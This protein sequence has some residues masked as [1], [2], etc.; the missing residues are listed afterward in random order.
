M[1]DPNTV[2]ELVEYTCNLLIIQYNNRPKAQATIK[3]F[4][5]A[6]LAN[7][8][9]WDVMNGYNVD[10]AVGK[11]LDIIGKYVGID[12][13]FNVTD[14]VDYFA[15]TDYVEVDPDSDQKYGFTT[16]ADFEEDQFNGTM[17]YNSV[18]TVEN[19]LNDDDFRILIKLKIVQNHSNHSHKSI[20]DSIFSFFGG[21][22]IPS[23]QGDMKMWYFVTDQLTD[24]IRAAQIKG[25]LP[26]P[27]G[28][29]MGVIEKKE[30]IPFFGF[31]TYAQIESGYSSPI[32]TG[33]TSYDEYDTKEGSFLSYNNI[34]VE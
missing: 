9:I 7:G 31:T 11:Q 17:N 13:F 23:S 18:L 4:T 30:G 24:R 5:D 22:L 10:T 8:I 1:A 33:F 28:V 32:I 19:K 3:A 26:R 25:V 34:T 12:R 15:L 2:R 20:D 14:P 29:G 27:M 21:S 6:I 16:Y